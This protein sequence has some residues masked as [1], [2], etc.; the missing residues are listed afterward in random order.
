MLTNDTISVVFDMYL[1]GHELCYTKII[2]YLQSLPEV[3]ETPMH[4]PFPLQCYKM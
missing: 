1:V 3:L 4:V 2:T